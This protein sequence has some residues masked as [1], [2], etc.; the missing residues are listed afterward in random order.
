MLGGEEENRGKLELTIIN[1]IGD[2][3]R[4]II[5][6]LADNNAEPSYFD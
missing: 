6:N 1:A 3:I 2:G 4:R 5:S